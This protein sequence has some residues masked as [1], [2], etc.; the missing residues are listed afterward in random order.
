M[1][2]QL[3]TRLELFAACHGRF[4]S[5]GTETGRRHCTLFADLRR[6]WIIREGS[7]CFSQPPFRYNAAPLRDTPLR[8]PT[9]LRWQPKSQGYLGVCVCFSS[10]AQFVGQ[11][12]T[13]PVPKEEAHC[14]GIMVNPSVRHFP[15]QSQ[16]GD[17]PAKLE[18]LRM[19]KAGYRQK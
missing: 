18:A 2:D 19:M 6:A 15:C 5:P 8:L 1:H 4:S 7:S 3:E 9:K 11:A 17:A 16:V 13:P 14:R 12:W 10:G